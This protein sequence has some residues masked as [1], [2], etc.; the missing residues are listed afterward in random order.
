[1]PESHRHM[2]CNGNAF[3]LMRQKEALEYCDIEKRHGGPC[4]GIIGFENQG[5]LCSRNNEM[6]RIKPT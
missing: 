4:E 6:K 1:M 3:H 5:A 2:A